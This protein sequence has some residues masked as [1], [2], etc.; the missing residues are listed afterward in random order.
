MAGELTNCTDLP[1]PAKALRMEWISTLDVRF[2]SCSS[3][4][5]ACICYPV[6]RSKG[7]G[8]FLNFFVVKSVLTI[9][10]H[11][12]RANLLGAYEV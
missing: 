2:V 11:F 6:G 10:G 9:G 12:G 8:V 5:V 3:A 7:M 4:F 1:L